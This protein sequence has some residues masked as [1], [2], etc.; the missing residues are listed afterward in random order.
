MDLKKTVALGRKEFGEE[1]MMILGDDPI[2]ID[3]ISTGISV[4]DAVTG[5]GGIPRGRITEVFGKEASLKTTF[6][7]HTMK[8]AQGMGLGVMYIDAEHALSPERMEAIGVDQKKM[9][10]CQPKSGEEALSLVE[11]GAN[12]GMGLIVVDSVAALTPQSEIDKEMGDA[13]MASLARLMSQAMRKLVK[14]I[15]RGNTAVIFVNQ[16]RANIG[17]F[18]YGAKEV[19]P[20]GAGLRYAASLRIKLQYV[21]Q[22]TNA[23]KERVSGKYTATIVKNK[24]ASPFKVAHFEGN[25]HGIDELPTFIEKC[26]KSGVLVASGSFIKLGEETLGQGKSAVSKKLR[27][28]PELK[29][30]LDTLL[31]KSV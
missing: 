6:C 31:L 4:I 25:E 10:F 26:L 22:V 7:L 13:P 19:T 3:V 12:S 1:S 17:G 16:L 28:N 24:L 20:G 18:G 11:F 2:K 30:K 14:P 29:A 5:I 15:S 27:E 23:A 8:Q 21:G 9:L